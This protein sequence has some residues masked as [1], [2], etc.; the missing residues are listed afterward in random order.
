M[1]NLFINT[2]N[3]DLIGISRSC[4]LLE[5]NSK[6]SKSNGNFTSFNILALMASFSL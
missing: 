2:L 3:F 1:N 5:H 6:T 4:N